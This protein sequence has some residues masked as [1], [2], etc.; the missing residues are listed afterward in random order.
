MEYKV[1]IDEFEGPLDLLLHLIKEANIDIY[2]IKISDITEQYLDY[3]KAM[4]ALNLS[5]ASEYLVMAAEL[6]EI[7]S[8][9]L[10]PSKDGDDVDEF[11]EDP[12]EA[13]IKRLVDY[14][15]YKEITATFKELEQ[16]RNQIFTKLPSNINEYREDNTPRETRSIS[17]LLEAFASF[18]ERHEYQ[19]PLHTKV[20][21]KEVSVSERISK[22][23]NILATS[24]EIN[25]E[26]LFDEWTREYV[27][28]TFLAILQM[29][30]EQEITIEQNDS[31]DHIYIKLRGRA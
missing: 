1:K 14:K 19:K 28:A 29:A 23:R 4:E 7:K 15:H 2:D 11:E 5:I 25:F 9:S 8:R 24:K 20:T 10:L 6:I 3:I 31:F 27:V 26:A 17:L 18:L 13:L 22:I 16:E 21:T 30:K 12:K